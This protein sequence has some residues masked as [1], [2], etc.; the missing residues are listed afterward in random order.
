MAPGDVAGMA[1]TI[2]GML[3]KLRASAE[4]TR[5]MA[6]SEAERRFAPDVIFQQ[7]SDALECLVGERASK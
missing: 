2:T 3:D 4:E 7:I 5:S 6:R 1:S